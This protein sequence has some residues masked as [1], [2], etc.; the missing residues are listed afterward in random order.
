MNNISRRPCSRP[1]KLNCWCI[2]GVWLNHLC[3]PF[4][5]LYKLL[6]SIIK[7]GDRGDR[8]EKHRE[9]TKNQIDRVQREKE[10]SRSQK[11]EDQ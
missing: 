9:N 7:K 4:N 1:E 8:R 2:D 11:S 6:I 10:Q 3:A 5:C